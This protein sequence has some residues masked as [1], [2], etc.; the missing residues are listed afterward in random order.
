MKKA[1]SLIELSIVILVIGIL[2]AG[3]VGSSRLVS[4]MRLETARQMTQSS[5][6]PS[7][8]GLVL[9]F[10]PTLENSFAISSVPVTPSILTNVAEPEE[11]AR[12]GRWNDVNPQ[13]TI[14]NDAIQTVALSQ[15]PTYT[16]KGINNLPSLYFASREATATDHYLISNLNVD[17]G[18]LSDITVFVV[19]KISTIFPN[20]NYCLFG[21][22][23]GGFDRFLCPR[24]A[25][26]SGNGST[27]SGSAYV[28]VAA[29][30]TTNAAIASTVL[31]NGVSSGSVVYINGTSA[32]TFTESHPNSG[33]SNFYIG[34]V[35]VTSPAGSFQGNIAEFIVF[36]RALKND[37]RKDVE[38]YLGKKWGIQVS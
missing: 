7:I 34:M 30:N 9:W 3:I 8:S 12:I 37:E 16:T 4:A 32:A 24:H 23:N 10:E 17:Y 36:N 11:G 13:S 1:F 35:G 6:V 31:R 29:L 20:T 33:T 2:I 14:K 5:P 27:S 19:Y 15:Q 22:D 21:N 28:T 38:K 18:Q 26:N 25:S